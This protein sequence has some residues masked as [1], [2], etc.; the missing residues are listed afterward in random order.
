MTEW[1]RRRAAPITSYSIL[2]GLA[3]TA[4]RVRI[5]DLGTRILFNARCQLMYEISRLDH[6]IMVFNLAHKETESGG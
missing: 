2:G 4:F 5:M 3:A 1:G 6:R